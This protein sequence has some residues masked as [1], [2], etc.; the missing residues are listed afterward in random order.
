MEGLTESMEDLMQCNVHVNKQYEEN[1][2]LMKYN[3]LFHSV[4]HE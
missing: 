2:I 4:D 1:L 3:K